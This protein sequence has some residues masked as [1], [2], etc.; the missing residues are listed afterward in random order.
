MDNIRCTQCGTVGLEPGFVE[1]SGQGARGF[2]RWIA[3]SLQLGPLG[4]AKRLGRP[5]RRIDA[6]RCPACA[7]LELFAAERA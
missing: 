3:G 6:W 2:A 1:D 4:N 7:H 5:R